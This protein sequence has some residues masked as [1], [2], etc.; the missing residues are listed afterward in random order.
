MRTKRKGKKGRDIREK[1]GVK[2]EKS[3]RREKKVVEAS[4]NWMRVCVL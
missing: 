3:R 4:E 2:E 1:T